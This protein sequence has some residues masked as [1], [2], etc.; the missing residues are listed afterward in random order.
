MNT[1]Q[2]RRALLVG[3]PAAAAAVLAIG[4]TVANANAGID[5]IFEAIETH[6]EPFKG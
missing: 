6:R 4:G 3:A 2:S 1:N 5:P